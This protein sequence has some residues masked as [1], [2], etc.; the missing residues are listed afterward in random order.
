MTA[1]LKSLTGEQPRIVLADPAALPSRYTQASG[2]EL[3]VV[4]LAI[5][6]GQRLRFSWLYLYDNKAKVPIQH[7]DKGTC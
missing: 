6:A 4:S 1:Y 7:N 5:Q 3:T 2:Q